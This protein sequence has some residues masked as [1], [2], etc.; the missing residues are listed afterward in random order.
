VGL[1]LR[2][3]PSMRLTSRLIEAIWRVCVRERERK[4]DLSKW[5]STFVDPNTRQ[6]VIVYVHVYIW[7]VY[8][9]ICLSVRN[10][11]VHACIRSTISSTTVYTYA[12][13]HVCMHVC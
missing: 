9:P 12:C 11:R 6:N 2:L 8:L 10:V 4:T 3:P 13:I 7:C 5:I 1:G